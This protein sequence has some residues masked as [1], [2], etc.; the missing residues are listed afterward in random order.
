MANAQKL[1]NVLGVIKM[2][3]ESHNQRSW[4]SEGEGC[5][6]TMCFAGHAVAMEGGKFFDTYEKDFG[7]TGYLSCELPDGNS[8][9]IAQEAQRILGLTD[10][11]ADHIFYN[12]GG[13]DD[14]ELAVKEVLNGEVPNYYCSGGSDLT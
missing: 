5:G 12:M 8:G 14:V 10:A 6:T 1:E 13:V 11:E 9:P 4:R 7:A 3:P 2:S